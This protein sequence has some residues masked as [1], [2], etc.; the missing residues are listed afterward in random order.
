MTHTARLSDRKPGNEHGARSS[1]EWAASEMTL[2]DCIMRP[3]ACLR[4]IRILF[5]IMDSNAALVFIG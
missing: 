4:R 2:T 5:E 1:P 3:T